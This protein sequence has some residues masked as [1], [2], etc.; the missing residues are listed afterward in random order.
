MTFAGAGPRPA[1]VELQDPLHG[2]HDMMTFANAATLARSQSTNS[3]TFYERGQ[4]VRD[5]QE[6]WI[7]DQ[8][9]VESSYLPSL[10]ISDGVLEIRSKS[11]A[12]KWTM[13]PTKLDISDSMAQ[14]KFL[15]MVVTTE[16]ECHF[17]A[18]FS[19][20]IHLGV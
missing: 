6:W 15:Y 18:Y 13:L 2:E 11:H 16:C 9:S 12:H 14:S 8:I 4:G 1:I 10:K 7:L 5:R 17:Q 19:I 20:K 3:L